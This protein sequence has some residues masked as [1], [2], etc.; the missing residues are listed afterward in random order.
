MLYRKRLLL[1]A[2]TLSKSVTIHGN[3][4]RIHTEI[5]LGPI[6]ENIEILDHSSRDHKHLVRF[7]R[8]KPVI[9]DLLT[10]RLVELVVGMNDAPPKANASISLIGHH[11]AEGLTAI[12][13]T[14]ILLELHSFSFTFEQRTKYPGRYQR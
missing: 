5:P 9:G 13:F 14:N 2:N 7:A 12:L 6:D 11:D 4:F 10:K 3:T 1:L 8:L